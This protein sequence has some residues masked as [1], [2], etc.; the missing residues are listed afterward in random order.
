MRLL[1]W[2][3]L[4]IPFCLPAQNRPNIIYIMSDDH[5]ADAISAYNKTLIQTPNIDRLAKEGMLFTRNFVANSICGPVRATLLTGQHSHKNGI[6]NNRT[7]FDSTKI[8]MPR[9]FQQ[10][11]YQT[12]LVG[13]WHLHSYPAGFDYWKILPG[14]GLY[15]DPRFISMNGDTTTIPGYAT[16]VICDEAIKW[17]DNRDPGK[18]FVLHIHHKA[19]HRYFLAPLKYIEQYHNKT[20]PEPNTLYNDTTGKGTAWKM[21]TMSILKD[22]KLCSDLKVDPNFILDIPHLKPDSLDIVYYHSIFNRIPESDRTAIKK[23]YEER[24]K[25]LQLTKANGNELLKYKYQWY[26]QDYLA[27]VA[28]VDE[29][30]GKIL[31]YLDKNNLTANTLVIYTGDQGMYLGENGWFDKRF[32]YDVSMQAPLLMRWPGKIKP[33]TVNNNMTQVIDYAPTMLDAAGI[34]PPGFMQGVSLVPNITGKQKKLTR[35]TLYYHYYE[36]TADHT[37]LPHLGVRGER[38]KLI[39]FYTVNEWE[40]YDMKTDPQEQN[41]LVN[42]QSWQKI[43]QRMKKE[44]LLLRDKYDDHEKA[45]ELY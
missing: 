26:M 34:S 36:Y 41:N 31:D 16:D 11:G 29:N 5:D 3:L 4:F 8:T 27:C 22:M 37:V 10:H 12:A 38:Y 15:F 40:L 6:K 1:P 18:P 19:P 2:L 7:R 43:L 45:G 28:S 9:L 14:Q 24:G 17:L 20:F 42:L 35:N 30:T 44:L 32:M 25:L 33:G 23:I 13:K 21:Q 39:Y